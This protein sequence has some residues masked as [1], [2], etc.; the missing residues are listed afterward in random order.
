[1]PSTPADLARLFHSQYA[2]FA[3]DISLWLELAQ[4]HGA[5]ILELGCGTGRVLN[6]LADAGHAVTGLDANPAMLERVER[7]LPP[8][9][10]DIV[11]LLQADLRNFSIDQRF[12]LAIAPLNVFAELD[13]GDLSRALS[14]VGKHLAPRGVLALDLPNP[15]EALALPDDEDELLQTFIETETGHAVQVS[16]HHRLRL[17]GQTVVVTWHYDELLPNGMVSRHR[18]ET[19]FHLR[20]PETLRR[21]LDE[22]GYAD[23]SFYG[24]YTFGALGEASKRLIVRAMK[25]T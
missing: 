14:T 2:D 5:P 19:T 18:F 8:G 12:P 9:T 1:M 22:S 16:A 3:E 10:T 15:P 13:D 23:V 20:S 4:R 21:L 11:T 24:D 17:S 25:P 6:H 7:N